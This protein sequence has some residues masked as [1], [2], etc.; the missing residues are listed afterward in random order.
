MKIEAERW[1]ISSIYNFGQYVLQGAS[2]VPAKTASPIFMKVVKRRSMVGLAGLGGKLSEGFRR[3]LF[4]YTSLCPFYFFPSSLSSFPLLTH[5]SFLCISFSS[6]FITPLSFLFLFPVFFDL[7][8]DSLIFHFLVSEFSLFCLLLPC[9][10]VSFLSFSSLFIFLFIH[11]S[12]E[13]VFYFFVC[14]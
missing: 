1:R 10:F 12:F 3:I 13:S 5:F 8:L 4:Y 6:S 2:F 7:F 14:V 9:C 11:F